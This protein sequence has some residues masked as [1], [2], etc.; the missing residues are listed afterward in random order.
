MSD[1]ELGIDLAIQY[2]CLLIIKIKS[3]ENNLNSYQVHEYIPQLQL[4]LIVYLFL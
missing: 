1:N 2:I 3:N 4:I